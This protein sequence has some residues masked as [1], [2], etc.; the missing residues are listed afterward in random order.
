MISFIDNQSLFAKQLVESVSDVIYVLELKNNKVQFLN[1]RAHELLYLTDEADMDMILHPDDREKRKLHVAACLTMKENEAREINLR[2]RAA[3]GGYKWFH[4]K[5]LVF[6]R[7][8][9]GSVSHLTGIIRPAGEDSEDISRLL[10]QKNRQLQFLHSELQTFTTLV[11]QDYLETLRQVYISLE[12]IISAEAHKFSNP[13][14]AHLRRAQSMLQKLNLLTKDIVAY[15]AIDAPE[16]KSDTVHLKD[17]VEGVEKDLS[18]KLEAIHATIHVGNLPVIKGYPLLLPV[19][20]NHLLVNAIRFRHPDR[21]LVI[22]IF[23][24]Q[25]EA[26]DIRHPGAFPDKSYYKVEVKDNGIG[27]DPADREKIFEMFY[28]GHDKAKYKGSGLGLAIVRKIMDIHGGYV[29]ADTVP[30]ERVSICC[31]FPV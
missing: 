24:K 31:Y 10:A 14:R 25:M 2:L 22:E 17:I 23:A 9:D 4:I 5:D 15:A 7:Q 16:G 19:L 30:G 28:Q 20:F 21:P 13:S 26:A 29:A 18:G 8:K 1:A 12:M 3:G 27:F 11:A 6:R